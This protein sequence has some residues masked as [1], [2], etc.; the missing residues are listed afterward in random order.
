VTI[1]F[2]Q[3][4]F[5]NTI[6]YG[7]T[8]WDGKQTTIEPFGHKAWRL[9]VTA[10]DP[11]AVFLQ[12]NELKLFYDDFNVSGNQPGT[13]FANATPGI[14]INAFNNGNGAWSDS[15]APVPVIIGFIFDSVI[16]VNSYLIQLNGGSVTVVTGPQDF[17]LEYSDDTTTGFDG[18]WTV[19]D[20]QVG[21][22]GWIPSEGRFYPTS[23]DNHSWWR[24]VFTEVDG[25][26]SLQS[27]GFDLLKNSA[28]LNNNTGT[29]FAINAGGFFALLD[30]VDTSLYN[31]LILPTL[32]APIIVAKKFNTPLKIDSYR[33]GSGASTTL[34]K[35]PKA[36]TV[37]FSDDSTD[38]QDGTW[39]VYDTQT[40]Q[41]G[42]SIGEFR[43][44]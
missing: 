30:V 12:I 31:P 23:G 29:V 33:M 19:F 7:Y 42:W 34:D 38:G 41:T 44:F 32:G 37:E 15:N 16:D 9:N 21:E 27:F 43:T 35:S 1:N 8:S 25:G 28:K 36:W 24:V 13:V 18:D 26:I 10:K 4:P 20:T 5:I 14:A 40:N 22:L 3:T 39:T 11:V 17:T 2:G 6:P